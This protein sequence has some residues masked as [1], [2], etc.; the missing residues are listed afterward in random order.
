MP[1][2][3][4]AHGNVADSLPKNWDVGD[5]NS[6]QR[7]VNA[8]SVAEVRIQRL[9]KSEPRST[10]LSERMKNGG[11]GLLVVQ[12]HDRVHAHGAPGGDVTRKQGYAGQQNCDASETRRICR[13][14]TEKEIA[15]QA[16]RS[17]CRN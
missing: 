15:Q 17:Q 8:T 13:L 2:F 1:S 4:Q 5:S 10:Q 11:R 3:R 9:L 16:C 14:H 6:A 7:G 12:R